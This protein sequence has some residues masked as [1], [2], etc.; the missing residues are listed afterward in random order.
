MSCFW[1]SLLNSLNK[2]DCVKLNLI[3]KTPKNL[4]NRLKQ[5]SHKQISTKC[6]NKS[7]TGQQ[8]EEI[9][10]HIDKYDINTIN[11]GYLCSTC[12]PF[13]LLFCEIL[14]IDINHKY[15]NNTIIYSTDNSRTEYFKSNLGHMEYINSKSK[16]INII[17]KK[18]NQI[19]NSINS[20]KSKRFKKIKRLPKKLKRI[21]RR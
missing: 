5:N 4:A 18:N 17:K 9:R 6:Q 7:L 12:D 19:H 21:I 16:I 11:N 1:D 15:L 13:I 10:I 20:I 3:K 8:R 2:E 14:Q